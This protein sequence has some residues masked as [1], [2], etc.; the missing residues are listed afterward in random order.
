[1][2]CAHNPDGTL[3][4]SLDPTRHLHCD[5]APAIADP[6]DKAGWSVATDPRR[7]AFLFLMPQQGGPRMLMLGCLRDAGTFATMSYAV[8]ERVD[9]RARCAD[10]CRSPTGPQAD[11]GRT[12]PAQR[13]QKRFQGASTT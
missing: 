11:P 5:G 1:M 6:E 2:A 12:G 9:R 8:G 13:L 7:R 10:D 3:L 4:P